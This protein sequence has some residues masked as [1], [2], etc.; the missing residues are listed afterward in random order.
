MPCVE[1]QFE[2][3][4]LLIFSF[5]L[6]TDLHFNKISLFPSACCIIENL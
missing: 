3:V 6:Y 2:S 5:H 4:A 1:S